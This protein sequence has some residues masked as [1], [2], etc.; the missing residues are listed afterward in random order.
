MIQRLGLQLVPIEAPAPPP[1]NN[2]LLVPS[3]V[4][5]PLPAPSHE[6]KL[7]LLDKPEEN[8]PK[9]QTDSDLNEIDKPRTASTGD[10]SSR[11]LS[12]SSQHTSR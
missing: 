4:D 7:S 2:P 6:E 9:K 12:I 10:S 5:D 1:A 8:A 11:Q 3:P